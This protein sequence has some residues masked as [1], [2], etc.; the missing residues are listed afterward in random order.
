MA[1]LNP[2]IEAAPVIESSA[3]LG[4][5]ERRE[6]RKAVRD[7]LIVTIGGQFERA[8][9]MLTALALRWG[10]DPETL[11]VYTGLRLYLDNTNRSS[12][13]VG[14]GAVQEIPVLLAAGREAEAR[15]VADV[16]YTAN[17]ATCL[18]YSLGLCCWAAWKGATAPADDPLARQWV[19]GLVA[20]AGLALL[21][22]TES[23]RIALLR[24]KREF[25][26]TTEL[27][28][29]ESA[30]SASA[31][32]VGLRVAGLWG[33]LAAVGV[34]L[35][36][37][38]IYIDRR[39]PLDLRW[40]RDWPTTRR[41]MIEGLPI[42]ANTAVFGALVGIDRA[43]ILGRLPDGER[44]AGL[45]SIAL[46]GTSWS[47]DVA[48]RLVLVA[49][50]YFQATLGRTNDPV[51]VARQALAAVEAQAPLLMF[52]SGIAAIVGPTFL[53]ML[54]P[55]YVDGLPA[56]RPLLVGMTLLGTA[57]PA[58]QL[59]ITLGRNL[60]LTTSAAIG[61]AAAAAAGIWCGD[62]WGLVGVA[63]GTSLGHAVAALAVGATAFVPRLGLRDWISHVA[64]LHLLGLWAAASVIA[65][66]HIALGDLDPRLAAPVRAAIFTAGFAVAVA[67]WGA[68]TGRFRSGRSRGVCVD[69]DEGAPSP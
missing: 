42:L 22:R 36:A 52:G 26:F 34:I 55:R 57:W 66:D 62:R 47:L 61:L 27:D 39:R 3:V 1:T 9:G 48:G 17:T 49:Y 43:V 68:R 5:D 51:R 33:L 30:L 41:L 64:R 21:K 2:P 45:Y 63:W 23:F 8:L 54:M 35:A 67:V 14:L 6:N 16:A 7:G 4:F 19:W 46:M 53:G 60:A 18:L 59:S 20:V 40:V 15:H 44:M 65:T 29:F 58:R 10:L 56:L 12:L 13:G 28:L 37:K 24:A 32:I 69:S 11:G 25:S 38:I 50:P 31:V